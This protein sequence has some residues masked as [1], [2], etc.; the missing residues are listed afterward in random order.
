M[1]PRLTLAVLSMQ[2]VILPFVSGFL[3]ALFF[4]EATIALLHAAGV[5]DF[6]GFS[7]APFLPLGI[8][9]F[10]ANAM[11]SSVFGI[12]MA[13]LLRVGA[14]AQCALGGCAR[15]RRHRADRGGRVC[16]RSGARHL[17]ERQPAAAPRGR[18]CRQ[19]DVGVGGARVHAR[20]HGRGRSAVTRWRRSG[21]AGSLG[22]YPPPPPPNPST[23]STDDHP[24]TT[25]CQTS[26]SL[27]HA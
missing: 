22:Y 3:A 2:K 19:C 17:A 6:A 12:L 21:G 20:V 7:T 24:A 13:W 27:P 14:R 9:E 18:V 16:R 26:A 15:V 8:P 5:V 11:W 1:T 23:A 4:R 25:D 10:I